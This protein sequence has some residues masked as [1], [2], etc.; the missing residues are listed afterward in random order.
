MA[1]ILRDEDLDGL[2]DIP[3]A[4]RPAVLSDADFDALGE[5][6]VAAPEGSTDV[7]LGNL[8]RQV[9]SGATFG[10]DDEIVGGVRQAMGSTNAIAQERARK[11]AFEKAHPYVSFG[12]K[13]LGA[14]GGSLL[15][16]SWLARG[17][18]V[19][20]AAQ[21]ALPVMNTGKLAGA[22]VPTALKEGAKLGVKGALWQRFGDS[23]GNLAERAATVAENAPADAAFGAVVGAPFGYLGRGAANI[24]TDL[25]TAGRVGMGPDA[26]ATQVLREAMGSGQGK[27]SQ[28]VLSQMI[29]RTQLTSAVQ[30]EHAEAII[31]AYGTI[32]K[33]GGSLADAE[34]AA[35]AAYNA[36]GP[37]TRAGNPVSSRVVRNR[38][39]AVI[40]AFQDQFKPDGG[41]QMIAAERLSGV[42]RPLQGQIK[43]ITR[44]I[45]NSPGEGLDTAAKV[46]TPRQEGA[47]AR[48][49][50]LV[51]KTVGPSDYTKYLK[52][53][54]NTSKLQQSVSYG[55]SKA[56]AKPFDIM[57]AV[58]KHVDIA[59]KTFGEPGRA[60]NAAGA[61]VMD[62][63]QRIPK[64]TGNEPPDVQQRM[65]GDML[66][67][68]KQV[69]RSIEVSRQKLARE[70]DRES[71]MYLT[72][73]K[74]DMDAVVAGKNR[75]WWRANKMAADD[76]RVTEAADLGRTV[77]LKEG[78]ALQEAKAWYGTATPKEKA[79]FKRGLARQFHDKLAPMGDL[80]DASKAFL[81]GSDVDEEGMRG[82][83][84]AVLPK[85]DAEKFFRQMERERTALST[86]RLDKGSPTGS[87][88]QEAKKR[89]LA[90]KLGSVLR[91]GNPMAVLEDLSANMANAAGEARDAALARQLFSTSEDD[92]LNIFRALSKAEQP[93]SQRLQRI[94][95]TAPEGVT[96]TAP[97]AFGAFEEEE[98]R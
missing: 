16:V 76:F 73:F 47:M 86:F 75:T 83:I 79:A 3:N 44:Q 70:G 11:A 43:S 93:P 98:Q 55:L 29:P 42:E 28:A 34:S 14:I 10:G 15:P 5:D 66:N 87:I 46:L 58:A 23:E 54:G 50:D 91:Y 7:G 1:R 60:L 18:A 35:V 97:G 95:Q 13:S 69:R 27:G 40:R 45:M 82:L 25:E 12:A 8:A 65:L 94:L 36:M 81:T 61:D 88:L 17:G 49:R 31:N 80:H 39:T 32:M 67:S 4:R 77:S 57:P 21:A 52:D 38:A 22:T 90:S 20:K 51:T 92:F 74:R 33:A 78:A 56:F 59:R 53:M 30:P 89:N 68:Y 2:P 24:A 64:P 96:A 63:W 37:T 9:L 41:P 62:W 72:R 71:A 19:G 26:A 85:K 6:A 84:S 48:N